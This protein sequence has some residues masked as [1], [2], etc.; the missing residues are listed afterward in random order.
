MVCTHS[1]N[2]LTLAHMAN[3]HTCTG[4]A[5]SARQIIEPIYPRQSVYL[6]INACLVLMWC[7]LCPVRLVS[8]VLC[9]L[10]GYCPVWAES[11]KWIPDDLCRLVSMT[12]LSIYLD[13]LIN[14]YSPQAPWIVGNR[15]IK[16]K[17]YI[18]CHLSLV[19]S[20][21]LCMWHFQKRVLFKAWLH[22]IG[23]FDWWY[24]EQMTM[25]PA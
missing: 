18:P 25:I 3:L 19:L 16:D 4:L 9:G 2:K 24:R 5:G 17:R 20:I 10:V 23:W 21:T 8:L 22:A 12:R 15:G 14:N 1:S 7:I 13:Y 6:S 11:P